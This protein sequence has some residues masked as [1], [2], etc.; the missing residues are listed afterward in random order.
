MNPNHDDMPTT[1]DYAKPAPRYQLS[2]KG[3]LLLGGI[4][5]LPTIVAA[6]VLVPSLQRTRCGGPLSSC[7][8]NLRQIGLA[9]QMYAVENKGRAPDSWQRLL[10]SEDIG[11]EAFICPAGDGVA[12]P[13]ATKRQQSANLGHGDHCSYFYLGTDAFNEQA[14]TAPANFVIAYELPTTHPDSGW[15]NV[16][17]ADIHV[18]A[19]NKADARKLL[20]LIATGVRPVVWPPVATLPIPSAAESHE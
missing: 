10:E 1:L 9:I 5:V 19:I 8:N 12:A 17:F 16:L 7:A 18:E 4:V 11:P 20:G 13:G 2:R 6:T 3:K 15:I 14:M